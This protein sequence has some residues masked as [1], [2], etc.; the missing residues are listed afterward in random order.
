[1]AAGNGHCSPTHLEAPDWQVLVLQHILQ[2]V[3]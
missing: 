1:M 2:T 3:S